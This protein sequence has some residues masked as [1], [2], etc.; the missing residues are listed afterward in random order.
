VKSDSL[1]ALAA[2]VTPGATTLDFEKQLRLTA[3]TIL[4]LKMRGNEAR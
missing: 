2:D 1:T 4:H 3:W